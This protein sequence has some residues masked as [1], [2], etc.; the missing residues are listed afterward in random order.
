MKAKL[1]KESQDFIFE[2]D[3]YDGPVHQ[4]LDETA[5]HIGYI[6]HIFNLLDG[7]LNDVI[8]ELINEREEELGTIVMHH[9]TFA[10]KID[11]FY[12]LVRYLEINQNK[13]IPVFNALVEDLR[14]CDC[15]INAMVHAE[16]ANMMEKGYDKVKMRSDKDGKEN[17]Y[18]QFTPGSLLDISNFIYKTG[19]KLNNFIKQKNQHFGLDM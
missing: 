8:C 4:F 5:P 6:T 9:F 10:S 12:R 1:R 13:Y 11:L 19:S 16:W 17:T 2:T 18:I 14:I 15:L 3:N 7:G